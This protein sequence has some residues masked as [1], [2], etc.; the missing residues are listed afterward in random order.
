MF[1]FNEERFLV[2]ITLLN[3]ILVK[4]NDFFETASLLKDNEI[5]RKIN[6]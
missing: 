1:P 3:E 5:I 6:K 2:D 4:I